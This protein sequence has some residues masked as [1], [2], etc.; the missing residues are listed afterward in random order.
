MPSSPVRVPPPMVLSL[1]QPWATLMA[2][3][4]KT[5]ETRSWSTR[6]RG[7][8]LIHAAKRK[9]KF[10]DMRVVVDN[11]VAW[12]AWCL[13]GLVDEDGNVQPGPLG[14]VVAHVELVDVLPIVAGGDPIDL[15]RPFIA[16][17][18]GAAPGSPEGRLYIWEEDE[19]VERIT[20]EAPFGDYRRGRFAWMTENAR[21]LPVPVPMRGQQGLWQVPEEPA[22]V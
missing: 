21:R 14:A 10:E 17:W 3:G 8:L 5:I 6:Y 7:P 18:A 19:A 11:P 15:S 4:V 16:W 20:H 12:A 22:D 13:A 2:L 9:P 1:W